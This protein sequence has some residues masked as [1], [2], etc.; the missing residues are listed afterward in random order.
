MNKKF[1][2]IAGFMA[3]MFCFSFEARAQRPMDK[4]VRQ[5]IRFA[6]GK[7][8][9]VISK[10]IPLGTSHL[11]TLRARAG[12]TMTVILKT[13]NRTSFTI[14]SPSDQI[15]E[16][17]DGETMWRGMLDETGTYKISIGTDRTA[18]YRLEVYIK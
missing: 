6:R 3:L 4:E 13:G 1:L 7:S 18:N 8:S 17:A 14:F 2:L 10:R 15:M 12:Q 9:A 5:T 16:G 11:Y